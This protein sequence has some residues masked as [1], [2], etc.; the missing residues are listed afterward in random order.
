MG[1]DTEKVRKEAQ[2]KGA[3]NTE[4]AVRER[5][6][7]REK[8]ERVRKSKEGWDAIEYLISQRLRSLGGRERSTSILAFQPASLAQLMRRAHRTPTHTVPR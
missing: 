2:G 5:E 4:D 7:Q 3:I 8:S 1:S 6:R